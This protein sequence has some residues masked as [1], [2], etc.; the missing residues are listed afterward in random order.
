M[1]SFISSL[2][3]PCF[4]ILSTIHVAAS[5]LTLVS[6]AGTHLSSCSSSP[7]LVQAWQ[8]RGKARVGCA[9][10]HVLAPEHCSALLGLSHWGRKS[11]MV[12]G[13]HCF[14]LHWEQALKWLFANL[15]IGRW[16]LF[17]DTSRDFLCYRDWNKVPAEYFHLACPFRNLFVHGKTIS[18]HIWSVASLRFWVSSQAWQPWKGHLGRPC[19]CQKKTFSWK[20]SQWCFYWSGF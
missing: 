20:A 19:S 4:Q 17:T 3:S 13:H 7:A 10:Q 16:Q 1:T 2:P 18:S 12:L 9:A 6:E 14:L 8:H 15:I 5:L 11:L